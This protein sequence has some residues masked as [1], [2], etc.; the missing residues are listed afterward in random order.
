MKLKLVFSGLVLFSLFLFACSSTRVN[1][2]YSHLDEINFIDMNDELR[3]G[4]GCI[5]F[6]D[7]QKLEFIITSNEEYSKF[8]ENLVDHDFCLNYNFPEI[9]FSNY[10][11]IGKYADS[12]GC[13]IDFSR[14]LYVDTSARELIY[15]INVK[16]E[17]MCDMLGSSMNWALVPKHDGFN[18]VFDVK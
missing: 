15:V 3:Q 6:G 8:S 11:L 7:E 1:P 4:F 5:D 9:D 17:G 14:N 12:G 2:E 18:I 13:S 10:I 16:A